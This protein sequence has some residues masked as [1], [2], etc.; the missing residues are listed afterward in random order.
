MLAT[1]A[2][3]VNARA[4]GQ[5][6]RY[7]ENR[8]GRDS[9]WEQVTHYAFREWPTAKPEIILALVRMAKAAKIAA[10]V[11]AALKEGE[12]LDPGIIP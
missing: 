8:G 7:F 9:D 4:I 10:S 2:D 6:T 5:L 12:T 11:Q 3:F 1:L